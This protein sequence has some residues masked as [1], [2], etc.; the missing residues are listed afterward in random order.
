MRYLL[1][2]LR[3]PKCSG[4]LIHCISGWDRTPHIVSLL[5]ILLWAEGEAH[6]SLNVDQ[7]LYL[8]VA[9]DWFLF[10]HE[11]AHRLKKSYE[12]MF[13]T[14]DVL[15]HLLSA[16]FSLFLGNYIPPTT[17]KEAPRHLPPQLLSPSAV[18][19]GFSILASLSPSSSTHTNTK[20]VVVPTINSP[21]AMTPHVTPAPP[22]PRQHFDLPS[23]AVPNSS[24][25]SSSSPSSS[26]SSSS[27]SSSSSLPISSTGVHPILSSP[28]LPPTY[29]T[30]VPPSSPRFLSPAVSHTS[31]SNPSTS[32]HENPTTSPR[33]GTPT[34]DEMLHHPVTGLELRDRIEARK[35]R[36]FELRDRFLYFYKTCIYPTYHK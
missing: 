5:R 34:I 7:F 31:S 9:Y 30:S 10:G 21:A 14:F 36:L 11:L 27:S 35:H 6:Q 18:P 26:P 23:T 20:S 32:Y 29:E 25:A 3:E 15:G 1:N 33:R 22:S 12:I 8:T 19:S 2:V 16:E 4:M 24:M 28:A 13:Y 17:A